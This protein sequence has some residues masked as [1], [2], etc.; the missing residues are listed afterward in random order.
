MENDLLLVRDRLLKEDLN[1]LY[2]SRLRDK[3]TAVDTVCLLRLPH[4]IESGRIIYNRSSYKNPVSWNVIQ[5]S[6]LIESF[7][8]DISISPLILYQLDDETDEIID[9]EQR[10]KAII[11]FLN[12]NFELEGLLLWQELNGMICEDLPSKIKESIIAN[13]L[14][15][16]TVLV[17]SICEFDPEI[18]KQTTYERLNSWRLT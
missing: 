4:L 3:L 11:D 13:R 12:G 6:R 5:K 16:M 18:V 7:L 10:V 8:L 15:T 9:G 17:N 14:H 1:I 2:E